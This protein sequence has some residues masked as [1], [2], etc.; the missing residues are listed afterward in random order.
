MGVLLLA[1][2]C[3]DERLHEPALAAELCDVWLMP[4]LELAHPLAWKH[5]SRQTFL[6]EAAHVH[7]QAKHYEPVV[8]I[9]RL[10]IKSAPNQ[11]VEDAGRL[12][13]ARALGEL[14]RTAEAVAVLKE[15]KD[16]S[17][18]ADKDLIPALEAKLAQ[19]KAE[20]PQPVAVPPPEPAMPPSKK[21]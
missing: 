6:E 5:L 7:W 16:K 13:L 1:A 17:L 20:K 10:W 15:I 8:E 2:R 9:A 14:D 21:K 12:K 4:N 3:A 18:K 11:N 19:Q